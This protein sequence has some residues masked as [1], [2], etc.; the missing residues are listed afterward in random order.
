MDCDYLYI[1]TS[2][3]ELKEKYFYHIENHNNKIKCNYPDAGFDLL[4]PDQ[5]LLTP[6]QYLLNNNTTFVLDTE[7]ICYMKSHTGT[8]LSYYLY[9]RSS[10]IKYP[11]RLANS[12]GIIDS[13]YR[14]NIKACFDIKNTESLTIPKY[15]RLVQIC[16]PTLKPLVVKLLD[17][18]EEL[19][20]TERGD[21]GFGS[22]GV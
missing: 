21:N 16:S 9:P 8:N 19:E 22:S 20:T 11:L 18:L 17:N 4:T 14:G 5:Y 2:N 6:D 15:T 1:Y 3:N 12:V 13:G 7:L 10:I